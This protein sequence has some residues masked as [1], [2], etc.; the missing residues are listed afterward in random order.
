[1]SVVAHMFFT[2]Y[3]TISLFAWPLWR[4]WLRLRLWCGKENRERFEERF[5]V[6]SKPRTPGNWVWIHAASV[7]ESIAILPLLRE[8]RTRY[9]T[10]HL[11]VTT[12][13]VTSATM[14]AERLPAGIVHQFAPID[15]PI[16]V[17]R[18]LEYWQPA[19]VLWT[20]SELWPAMLYESSRRSPVI[21]I[22]ARMSTRSYHRWSRMP[23]M[24]RVILG[25]FSHV[26]A[27]SNIDA[28]RF[29][30]LGAKQLS[31]FQNLKMAAPPLEYN[32]EDFEH[33]HEEIK[34]RQSWVAASTHPG[35]EEVI[36]ETH[37][38]AKPHWPKLLT[39]IIPRHS[40]RGRA[41]KESLSRDF[42]INVALRSL[43]EPIT[44]TTDVYIA[45][46]MGELGLFYRLAAVVLVGG[47]LVSN[48]GGHNF[49]EA[50]RL[51]CP[52]IVGP[53]MDNFHDLLTTFL[54]QSAIMQLAEVESL[55]AT[56]SVMLGRP[57]YRAAIAE[58]GQHMA[59]EASQ[60]VLAQYME[61]I[62]PY[63]EE[64]K[65]GKASLSV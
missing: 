32:I 23:S 63:L 38:I 39:I 29:G 7:G 40:H 6:A 2:C 18:F 53:Y 43:G 37:T 28:E 27:G 61:V 1:M 33:L 59:S 48:V 65:N 25:Y 21:L 60:R 35:E 14:M 46:T 11:L 64:S 41:L 34:G 44:A 62:A 9:P 22:S 55:P 26:I 50:V 4:G 52:T 47:S 17:R 24:A 10:I 8:M 49:L 20:E 57:E 5:G 58:V 42:A 15:S 12:G 30:V 36:A 54:E 51:R 31:N 16:A 56:L 19:L 13:T 3:R 45:D